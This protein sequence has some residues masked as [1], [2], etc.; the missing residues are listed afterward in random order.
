MKNNKL[1]AAAL[2]L[3]LIISLSSCLSDKS[4]ITIEAEKMQLSGGYK[5]E[6]VEWIRGTKG[7]WISPFYPQAE[8]GYAKHVFNGK[9]GIYDIK[10]YFFDENDGKCTY[11]FFINDKKI[12]S[13]IPD[14]D[15]GGKHPGPYTYQ[16]RVLRAVEV[17]KTDLIKIEGIAD[18][19]STALAELARVDKI[20]FSISKSSSF[21]AETI[22]PEIK[23]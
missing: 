16:I 6:N 7:I 15:L 20:E 12:D 5:V 10:I 17:K 14:K 4:K 21:S 18:V 11:N 22:D 1:S 19:K 9:D 3:I 8:P 13:W 23:M 2:C